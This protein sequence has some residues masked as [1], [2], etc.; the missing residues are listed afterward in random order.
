LDHSEGT[1]A[2]AVSVFVES[3]RGHVHRIQRI[4]HPVAV[5]V[6]PVADL[7]RAGV[8]E[9]VVIVAIAG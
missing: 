6:H 8:D 1:V 9:R 7:V 5:I 4:D 3:P 2:E